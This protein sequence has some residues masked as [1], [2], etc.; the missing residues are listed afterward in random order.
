M[1]QNPHNRTGAGK[2]ADNQ[3]GKQVG[4]QVE[5]GPLGPGQAPANDPLKGL[6]GVMAGTHIMEAIVILL[7]LTVITRVDAGASATTFNMVYVIGLGA[8]MIVA[9]FLQK[10]KWAD[11]LNIGLQVLVVAGF[12]VHP[13]MGAMGVIFALCWWY[14]YHLRSNLLRRMERGLLPSQHLDE[15]GNVRRPATPTE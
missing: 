3:A 15:E 6:R 13:A 8:A 1:A 10:L 7:V 12:I 14:V 9:A 11:W 2:R 4:K 5:Y